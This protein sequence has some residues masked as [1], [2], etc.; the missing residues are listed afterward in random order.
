[1]KGLAINMA[2]RKKSA[3]KAKPAKKKPLKKQVV[4]KKKPAAKKVVTKK[5][6]AKKPLAKT[7]VA[8]KAVQRAAPK[9][10]GSS[11]R[12]FAAQRERVD[13][14]VYEPVGIG[15]SSG[16]QGGSLQGLSG[17]AGA[18]S[19]SVDELLEEG[20][21]FEAEIVKGVQDAGDD[22]EGEVHTHEVPEDDVPEEYLDNDD[23]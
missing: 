21:S 18:N 20:N 13:T 16:G 7:P 9:K 4:V 1:V 23:K 12:G 5:V 14:L 11:R 17:R 10:D 8:K 3:K 2:T 6:V 22:E 15:A 19:E